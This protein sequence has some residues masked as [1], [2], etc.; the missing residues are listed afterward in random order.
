[1]S[2]AREGSLQAPVR[3]P[4]DWQSRDFK[5]EEKLFAELERVFDYCHGCRRCVSLC[6]SFPTLFD[7]VDESET[8]E[9]D[10]VAK[11]DYWK[12]VD[13]CFLCDLCYMTKCPYVPPHEWNI[14]FPHLMLRAKA[15]R[16]EKQGAPVR[17]KLLTS[18]DAVGKMAGLPG[19]SIVVNAANRSKPL[20]KALQKVAGIHADARIPPYQ[21]PPLR[22]RISKRPALAFSEAVPGIR[23]RGKV[24]LFATCYVNRNESVLGEDLVAVLGHNNIA[25]T[26][27]QDEHCCGMPKLELGDLA[28]VQKAKERNIPQLAQLVDQGWDLLALVPS[29]VLMFKQELPLLFPN[30]ESV[31]K[32]A[33]AFFD[34]FEYLM[35]RHSEGLM[36]TE[37]FQSLG[38]VVYHASCHQRVQ[39]IGPK[40]RE[41]LNLVPDT[42]VT[43]IERCSGHDGT[44]GVKVET[45]E[46][47]MKIARPVI[48]GI[49]KASPDHYGSDCPIAGHHLANGIG[50]GSV[51]KHPI[52]LLRKAYGI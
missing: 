44:Y 40:T 38:S 48:K 3:H 2:T 11:E 19:V 16:F 46:K 18:T 6:D 5:D 26:I 31:R 49:R 30:D 17:D 52:S 43:M 47:A 25:V 32:V 27:A 23:T 21:S 33:E 12:V 51:P 24:A 10:G 50:D 1:M 36:V 15:I 13:Q 42:Q 35:L 41:A 34:P 14:D 7:L 37:F 29:C 22:K 39:N 8:M 9:V 45:F 20:R 28:S 4:I